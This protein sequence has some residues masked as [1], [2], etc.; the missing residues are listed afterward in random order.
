MEKIINNT[1]IAL[2][3]GIT[4]TSAKIDMFNESMTALLAGELGLNQF[5][6]DSI[7]NEVVRPMEDYIRLRSF[8]I[9]T[10]SLVI[11]DDVSL[12]EITGFD[13]EQDHYD[14][15]KLWT[16]QLSRRVTIPYHNILASYDAGYILQGMITVDDL[17]LAI[18]TLSITNA[19]V[20]TNYTFISAGTPTA[21][22]I[23]IGAS[24]NATAT[25]I[26]TK[27]GAIASDDEVTLPLGMTATLTQ[28]SET[29][30]LTLVNANIPQDLKLA[31]AYLVAGSISDKATIEGISDYSLGGKSVTFRS[32]NEQNFIKEVIKKY[33]SNYQKINVMS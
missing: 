10:S 33:A 11:K 22:Q 1:D 30:S 12:L 24:V 13:Y 27:I 25:N 14:K 28:A 7:V 29:Q 19:G 18:A 15:R 32:G 20:T 21:T 26:A 31:V 6:V 3:T 9:D 8:P 17:L 4:A 23:L 2:Y 5:R 16:S